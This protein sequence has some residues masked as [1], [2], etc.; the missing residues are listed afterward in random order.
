MAR[1]CTDKV[2]LKKLTIEDM[3]DFIKENKIDKVIDATHPFAKEVSEN[4]KNSSS[5][6]NLPLIRF[7]R[8]IKNLESKDL[9]YTENAIQCVDVLLNT[10]GILKSTLCTKSSVTILSFPVEVNMYLS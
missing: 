5:E 7:E 6:T 9:V 4:I 2:L 1:R 8:E 3:V 10:T